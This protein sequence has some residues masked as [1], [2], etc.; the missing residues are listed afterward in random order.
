MAIIQH[1]GTG[2]TPNSMPRRRVQMERMPN[3]PTMVD[4]GSQRAGMVRQSPVAYRLSFS[5]EGVQMT[6]ENTGNELPPNEIK[7]VI[8]TGGSPLQ[9]A[10]VLSLT[11]NHL[12]SSRDGNLVHGVSVHWVT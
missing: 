6:D 9:R 4:S 12:C 10:S 11:V 3:R 8:T 1:R 5:K 2:P 7:T